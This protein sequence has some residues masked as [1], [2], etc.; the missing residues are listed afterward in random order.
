MLPPPDFITRNQAISHYS[1][2][3]TPQRGLRAA[4]KRTLTPTCSRTVISSR[5]TISMT[6]ATIAEHA[7]LTC[8][9]F[10]TAAI[11][12]DR[13]LFG[14]AEAEICLATVVDWAV[15]RGGT[16]IAI[17]W[18]AITKLWAQTGCWVGGT[19]RSF[20]GV[21]DWGISAARCISAR[22]CGRFGCA[23]YLPEPE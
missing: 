19:T 4:P 23:T 22:I 18:A 1:E 8:F 21:G 3:H 6:R 17:F 11:Y 13:D 15:F 20:R 7:S 12:T 10:P 5:A 14:N 2:A 16:T 9:S